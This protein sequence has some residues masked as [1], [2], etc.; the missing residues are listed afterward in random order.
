M[1]FKMLERAILTIE[2]ADTDTETPETAYLNKY[3]DTL[4]A[5]AERLGWP[6]EMQATAYGAY[7]ILGENL[8]RNHKLTTEHLP[9]F[10]DDPDLQREIA[11]AQFY[12]MLKQLIRRRGLAWPLYFYSMWNSGI[13]FNSA[14]DQRIRAELKRK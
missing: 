1:L 10:L 11:R 14:Y 7:Q 4:E 5:N 2:G 9:V 3:R 6:A 8:A 13:N 12:L